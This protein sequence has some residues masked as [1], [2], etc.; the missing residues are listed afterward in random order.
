M[1]G[2]KVAEHFDCLSKVELL[3]LFLFGLSGAPIQIS[4]AVLC[5]VDEFLK[6]CGE[7]R[8]RLSNIKRRVCAIRG[9][10]LYFAYTSLS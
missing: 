9:F 5:A 10:L 6:L 8:L 4:V 3:S 1:T 7:F 2:N